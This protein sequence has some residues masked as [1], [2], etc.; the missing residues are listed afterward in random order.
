MVRPPTAVAPEKLTKSFGKKPAS[1][2]TLSVTVTVLDPETVVKGLALSV[3]VA[4]TGV[5]S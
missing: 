4:L 5:I 1:P 3:P 2:D